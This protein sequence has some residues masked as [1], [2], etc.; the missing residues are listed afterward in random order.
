M[1]YCTSMFSE[2]FFFQ[3]VGA[4]VLFLLEFCRWFG[5]CCSSSWLISAVPA[6]FRLPCYRTLE[7]VCSVITFV[8]YNGG[9]FRGVF[10]VYSSK[11]FVL[12]FSI[13]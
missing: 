9:E 12:L 13:L 4:C 5:D 3:F 11:R 2:M 10:S 8:L 1:W 7:T 6:F